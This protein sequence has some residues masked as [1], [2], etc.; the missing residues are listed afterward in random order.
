VG[1][2]WRIGLV[3]V[4]VAAL[5]VSVAGD[6]VVDEATAH[7]CE[8]PPATRP[9]AGKPPADPAMQSKPP[10]RVYDDFEGVAGAAPDPAKWTVIEGTGWDRGDQ[11][12][13]RENAVLDGNGHLLLRAEK[14]DGGFTSGRV[15]TRRKAAFG[16][17]TLIARIKMPAGKG[18][19]PA[20]WLMGADE[21][22]HPWPE[23]G[24]IDVVE[25][26]SDPTRRYTSLHGPIP[27]VENYLQ[28]QVAGESPDLS[29]DFHDYWVIRQ[30]DRIIVGIDDVV[31]ADFTPQSLPPTA[32]WVYNK[33]FCVILK[34]AVGGPWAG[35]PDDSTVFPATM[36]VDW[37]HW[38][39]AL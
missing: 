26:V 33:P 21:D 19:W 15:E 11:R 39:P 4:L 27:D 13:A 12:Y 36:L 25:V 29:A 5:G 6:T 9:V 14:V 10:T 1:A 7:G 34:L 18:L 30:P 23:A 28:A 8:D 20:F 37:L 32:T 3:G 38:E 16:Y 2:T 35:P 31:W 24:E 22:N 17:G